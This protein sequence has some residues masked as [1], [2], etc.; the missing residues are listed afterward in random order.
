MN[1]KDKKIII[2]LADNGMGIGRAARALYM[3]Y[4]NVTHH[5]SRIEQETGLNPRDFHDLCKLYAMATEEV[6][7]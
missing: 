1:Q 3:S 4:N 2:A 5:I 7:E 6:E